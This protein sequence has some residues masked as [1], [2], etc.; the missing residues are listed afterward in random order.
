MRQKKTH[1]NPIAFSF[2][3]VAYGFS[4]IAIENLQNANG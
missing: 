1:P 4:P 3:N 2:M